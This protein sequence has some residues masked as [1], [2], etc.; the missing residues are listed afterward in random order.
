MYYYYYYYYTDFI[1][2]GRKR[3][4]V[5]IRLEVQLA[6]QLVYSKSRFVY[7]IGRM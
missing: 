4:L 2:E 5:K 6:S 7:S 3:T 1:R